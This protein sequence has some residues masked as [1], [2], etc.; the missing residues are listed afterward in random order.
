MDFNDAVNQH[1]A[2]AQEDINPT[3]VCQLSL[4]PRPLTGLHTCGFTHSL[5]PAIPLAASPVSLHDPLGAS[6]PTLLSHCHCCL[7]LKTKIYSHAHSLILYQCDLTTSAV[8]VRVG[9]CFRP[10]HLFS[11]GSAFS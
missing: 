3:K 1:I 5:I 8:S 2:K 11:G 4:L 9:A 10:P 7:K 6:P